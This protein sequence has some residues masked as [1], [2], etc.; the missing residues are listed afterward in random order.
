MELNEESSLQQL[1][2][3]QKGVFDHV[4]RDDNIKK[5]QEAARL[6]TENMLNTGINYYTSER[7]EDD[8]DLVRIIRGEL[9]AAGISNIEAVYDN[10][11]HIQDA[12]KLRPHAQQYHLNRFFAEELNCAQVATGVDTRVSRNCLIYEIQ[13]DQWETIVKKQVIPS[14]VSTGYYNG[15]EQTGG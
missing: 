5:L 4:Q 7:Q 8:K 10:N 1:A 2:D 3:I 14:L 9:V 15:E 11:R 12:A 13:P 6:Q